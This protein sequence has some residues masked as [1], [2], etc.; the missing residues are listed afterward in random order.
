MNSSTLN[1]IAR[2]VRIVLVKMPWKRILTFSFFVLLSAVFWFMQIYRQNFQTTCY[3][4]IRYV[5]VPDSITFE[6]ELPPGIDV[7]IGTSGYELFRYFFAKKNDSLD[8]NVADI[9]RFSDRKILQG[10]MFEQII[11]DRLL[12]TSTILDYSPNRISFYYSLLQQK[13]IP[14]ILD[15]QVFL[16]QGYLLSGDIYTIPDSV[17]AYGGKDVLGSLN[18]AYTV[19]DTITIGNMK[20]PSPLV[21]CIKPI[22]NV[23]FEPNNVVVV[24]PVDKYTQKDVSIPITCNHL[25]ADLRIKFFPSSVKVS[26]LVGLSQYSSISQRDFSVELDYNDLKNSAETLIPLRVTSSPDHIHN[27]SLSPSEV[28][29]LFEQK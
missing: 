18:Y 21:Y 26:F 5:S 14:V 24:V 3:I 28:E 22:S 17:I 2:K 11:K 29:F 4:P 13:K 7:T 23:K 25:P 9:I 19:D 6:N 16:E 20:S 12:P 8:I 27:L 10:S 15:G 1:E